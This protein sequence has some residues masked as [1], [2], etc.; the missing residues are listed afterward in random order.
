M[1]SFL[2]EARSWVRF[3]TVTDRS[4]GSFARY[5]QARFRELDFAVEIAESRSGGRSFYNL[6]ARRGPAGRPLLLNT[7]LDTVP[8]GPR[9]RWTAT[10]GNPWRAVLRGGR[11]YGL[12]TA[13][14][15][16]NL[17]CVWEALRRLGPAAFRRPLC[18]A[19]TFGEESGM[20][21][22]RRLAASW[23]GPRPVF[24]LVGEPSLLR[25]VDR[26][27]GYL[28]FR[29]TLENLPILRV[30]GAVPLFRARTA[31]VSAHSSTPELGDSALARLWR[32]L[33]NLER[34]GFHPTVASLRGGAAVNQVPAEAEAGVILPAWPS[35]VKGAEVISGRLRGPSAAAVPWRAFAD[36]EERLARRFRPPYT[37]NLGRIET[38]GRRAWAIFDVR[39][40][41]RAKTEPSVAAVRAMA[42]EAAA[43]AGVR[44]RLEVERNDPGLAG[45]PP[46]RFKR[47]VER[48]LRRSGLPARWEE[49]L[50]CTEAGVYGRWGVPAAV[51]GPG[52]SRG[53]AHR[54]NE[55][56]EVSQLRKAVRFYENLLRA[57]CLES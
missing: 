35:A 44:S 7:H 33:E 28:A 51:L 3:N 54:P 9:D 36:L 26:H 16:L 29:W 42:E 24:A 1:S 52:L 45:P 18:V 23:R 13:D 22:A 20:R 15:K 50:T 40:P 56:V 38:A 53:N 5:L 21:G 34:R 8:A 12:G 47:L 4:N 17:L 57:W 55:R 2:Q 25:P 41:A 46:A 43:A 11:L 19:G 37:A 31:G 49:K 27:R 39:I 10:G 48:A 6:L 30:R 32:V 14:T